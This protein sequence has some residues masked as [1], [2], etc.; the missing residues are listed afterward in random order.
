MNIFKLQLYVTGGYPT[1]LPTPMTNEVSSKPV[2]GPPLPPA[3][4]GHVHHPPAPG[5]QQPPFSM[6]QQLPPGSSPQPFPHQ[7]DHH[8]THQM[9]PTPTPQATSASAVVSTAGTHPQMSA[10]MGYPPQPPQQQQPPAGPPT[11]ASG[12]V[13]A[14][15]PQPVQNSPFAPPRLPGAIQNHNNPYAGMA[16]GQ[17]GPTPNFGRYPQAPAYQ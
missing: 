15:G 1:S 16:A 7:Q 2:N 8:Q 9:Q 10:F 3:A 14:A 17:R 4:H 12:M 6:H 11:S 5:Q 13:S